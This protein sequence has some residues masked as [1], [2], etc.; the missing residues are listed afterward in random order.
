MHGTWRPDLPPELLREVSS[1]LHVPADFVRFHAVCKAWRDSHGPSTTTLTGTGADS[2]YFRCVFA[3]ASYV[4]PP[5]ISGGSG[6]GMNWVASADGTAVRYFTASDPH[7]PT[8]HDPLAGGPPTHLPDENVLRR[9]EENPTGIIYNDGAVLL[10]SK[11]DSIDAYTTEFIH[12][13]LECPSDGEFCTTRSTA[14]IDSDD[15]L[16]ARPQSMPRLCDSYFYEHSYVLESRG[17]LLWASVH[18]LMYYPDKGKNGVNDLVDAL[19]MSMHTL[20]EVTEGPEK[21]MCLVSKK[22]KL[23][24][25]KKDGRSLEDRVLFLGWPNSFAVDAA[26][27]GVSGGFTYFLYYDDQGGRPRHE[28][29]GVFRYNLIDNTAEFVEWLPQGRGSDMCMWLLPQLTIAPVHQH[30]LAATT[31]RSNNPCAGLL[32]PSLRLSAKSSWLHPL[33]SMLQLL[34]SWLQHLFSIFSSRVFGGKVIY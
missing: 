4:S 32:M 29:H 30:G 31:S 24:W 25:T 21:L 23:M 3:N 20:E 27:L 12:R 5:P 22:E 6:T 28:R 16:V 14:A 33:F 18:I 11:H 7:G 8:L 34:F 26:H 10:F 2:L 9:L 1:R 15:V 17:E 13:T 19:S